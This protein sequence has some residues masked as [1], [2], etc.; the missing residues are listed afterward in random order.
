[1]PLLASLA[2]IVLL[3]ITLVAVAASGRASAQQDNGAAPLVQRLVINLLTEECSAAHP[4]LAPRLSGE[5][6]QWLTANASSLARLDDAVAGLPEQQRA[7]LEKTTAGILEGVRQQF[8]TARQAGGSMSI[9]GDIIGTFGVSG[10]KNFDADNHAEAVGMYAQMMHSVEQAASL[11][12]SRFPALAP[13]VGKAQQAWRTRD[14]GI[15]ANVKGNIAHWRAQDPIAFDSY[16]RNGIESA[17][18][19]V[20]GAFEM[21]TGESFCRQFFNELAS[22]NHRVR[23]PK[24]F[25]FL[26]DGPAA[27]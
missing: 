23:T 7:G 17:R 14:A 20:N 3:A 11:C 18:A 4:E 1:M 9:C 21:G 15:I 27:D 16:E 5:R 13:L 6:T 12:P 24:M 19:M 10:T 2:R 22:G 26:E 25:A 8:A